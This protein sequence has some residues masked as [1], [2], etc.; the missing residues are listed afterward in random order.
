MSIRR[1]TF[2]VRASTISKTRLPLL[3]SWDGSSAL[4]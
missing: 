4:V 1:R 3:A 2:S